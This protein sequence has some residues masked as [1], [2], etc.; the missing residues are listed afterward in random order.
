[1]VLCSS[2]DNHLFLE[3]ENGVQLVGANS[4]SQDWIF[5]HAP[6]ISVTRS[7]QKNN[8][9]GITLRIRSMLCWQGVL[10][11]MPYIPS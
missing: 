3:A 9:R 5:L 4:A 1:M 2:A 11:L 8:L 7:D 6:G 10:A